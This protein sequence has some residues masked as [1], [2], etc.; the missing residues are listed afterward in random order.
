VSSK[1]WCIFDGRSCTYQAGHRPNDI[2]EMASLTKMATFLTA[3]R[4]IERFKL[5]SNSLF[6]SVSENAAT[7]N[8]NL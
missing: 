4:L 5:D 8:G 6:F 3:L 7:I 1:A 2:R